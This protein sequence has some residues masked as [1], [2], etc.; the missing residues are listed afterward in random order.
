MCTRTGKGVKIAVGII[1]SKNTAS[2][3]KPLNLMRMLMR[4]NHQ[5]SSLDNQ[6]HLVSCQS[7]FR[8]GRHLYILRKS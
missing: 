6:K 4:I 2:A 8:I 7:P 3:K 5:Q 1:T